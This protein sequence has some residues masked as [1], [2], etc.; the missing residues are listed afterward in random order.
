MNFRTSVF[1]VE[2]RVARL[3]YNLVRCTNTICNIIISFFYNNLYYINSYYYASSIVDFMQS[4]TFLMHIISR[5]YVVYM[6]LLIHMTSIIIVV[7]QNIKSKT[8]NKNTQ[9]KASY[10]YVHNNPI[11]K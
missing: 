8:Y 9:N 11:L 4:M 6:A 3:I 5:L 7:E 1:R 10:I 2:I